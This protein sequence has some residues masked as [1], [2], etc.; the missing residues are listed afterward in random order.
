MT[1]DELHLLTCPRCDDG[2]DIPEHLAC[3]TCAEDTARQARAQHR[4]TGDPADLVAAQV[5]TMRSLRRSAASAR[6]TA[7][8]PTT[9][10]DA[11]QQAA[12]DRVVAS[13]LARAAVLERAADWI[14]A[15]MDTAAR[16]AWQRSDTRAAALLVRRSPYD[17]DRAAA[18][19]A[20]RGPGVVDLLATRPA[21]ETP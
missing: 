3:D 21:K 16:T 11:A 8:W 13:A 10:G 1:P 2:A 9:G 17:P 5:A 4:A 14:A 19:V 6:R 20:Q 15:D 12:R 18:V 7:A